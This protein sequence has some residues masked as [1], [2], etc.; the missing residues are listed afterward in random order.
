MA[1]R[2]SL[3]SA[4]A[5]DEAATTAGPPEGSEVPDT[6]RLLAEQWSE[7]ATALPGAAAGSQTGPEAIP[8]RPIPTFG[9]PTG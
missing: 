1:A 3:V 8:R 9:L 5:E 4:M 7:P 2:L 6:L